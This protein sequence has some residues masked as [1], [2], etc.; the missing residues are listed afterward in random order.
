M[1]AS[2]NMNTRTKPNRGGFTLV[3]MLVVVAIIGI[4]AAILIPTLYGVILQAQ[5]STIAQEVNQMHQAVESYKQNQQDYPP[6]FSNPSI[7]VRHFRKAFPRH[8]EVRIV[9]N[10]TGQFK[11]DAVQDLID[12]NITPSEALVFWLSQLANDP[13]RPLTAGPS[14]ERKV[15]FPFE[16]ER[17]I[18]TR[19][20][21]VGKLRDAS[22][23]PDNTTGIDLRLF[24]YVPEHGVDAPYIYFDSRTYR[25][26]SIPWPPGATSEAVR[27]YLRRV[28]NEAQPFLKFANPSTFQILSAGIDADYGSVPI[29]RTAAGAIDPTATGTKVFATGE[30]DND[31]NDNALISAYD[32]GDFENI[33]NF[34]DGKKFEDHME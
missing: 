24:Q 13:R 17:L 12:A 18:L 25:I 21:K 31:P 11:I 5:R 16:E 33:A 32:E 28:K 9:N 19:T 23:V 30:A 10:A 26:A 8:D 20:I 7:V 14:A 2:M 3:E 29:A 34:S 27:P 6:D 1:N 4:L 15:V 22:N